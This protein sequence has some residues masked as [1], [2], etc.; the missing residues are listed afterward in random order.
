MRPLSYLSVC[1]GIEAA[2]VAWEPLG[3]QPAAFA[4]FDPEHDYSRGPDFASRVLGA[5]FPLV[6]NLGDITRYQEWPDLAV[7]VLVGGTP[8]QSFSIAGLR[9]GLGDERGNLMLV[10]AAI[11]RRYRPS[12]LAWENV[13]GVLSSD[14]GRDF[15]SLLGLLSGRRVTVPRGGWR[16]AGVVE[17]IA[18]AYGLAW[19]VLDAQ[20][21]RVD[22]LGRAVP[23]RR[24]RVFL[25]GYL[26]DWCRAGAVLFE[27]E[28]LHGNSAPRRQAREGIAGTLAG[29]ARVR[30]GFSLD[31]ISLAAA[32]TASDGGVSGK[33]GIHGRLVPEVANPLT[34]RMHERVNTTMDEG[35][36]MVAHALRAEGFDASEDGT[37][38]GT[39][40]IPVRLYDT[41]ATLDA[42]YGR[43]QG[44][45]GQD[46]NH[47]HSH[48]IPIAFDTTQITHPE[49][50]S[51]PRPGD[52][53]H[54]LSASAHPP[55][56]AFNARQDPVPSVGHTGPLDTDSMTQ[57]IAMSVS[58]RGR[59]GGGTIELG[60][61]A[62]MTLRAS[63]G[64][65]DKPHALIGHN[66]G[67]PIWRVRR[68]TPRECERLQGY[69]DDYTL[70]SVNGKPA[71]DGP[72][73]KALGNSMA[74]NVM[75]WLGRRI[76]L[77]RAIP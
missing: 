45:S 18:S 47:G 56:I 71:A 69:P 37:G 9:E 70:I 35:Q 4:Q 16:S 6:P 52:A 46:L 68:L 30:G 75:R 5:R 48:L 62:A 42:S 58:I 29:G 22:G 23:Q 24:R 2:T 33:D 73:Y 25:V 36:T 10:Y 77:V 39:P 11:A 76:E 54:P 20:H 8:C 63:Q 67:P 19:R 53:C 26:G 14:D 57:C 66:G 72:R 55:A 3:W 50:R 15:A 64:G 21:V 12:W 41:T 1:S 34:A 49:N 28:G 74:V 13:P 31:D 7:D 40:I 27:R 17:G 61:D 43:L 60:D 65:G 59:E 38:R 44:A 51:N 32:L